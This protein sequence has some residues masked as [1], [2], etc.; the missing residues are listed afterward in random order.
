MINYEDYNLPCNLQQTDTTDA[1]LSFERVRFEYAPRQRKS[2]TGFSS[3][4]FSIKTRDLDSWFSFW[5]DLH[6]GVDSFNAIFFL[7]ANQNS[8]VL[9][10]TETYKLNNLGAGVF[11]INCA[12]EILH[13]YRPVFSD[14]AA[15]AFSDCAA[16][17]FDSCV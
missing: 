1:P 4:A 3:S 8:K 7:D 13:T 2:F 6:N 10:F 12:L 15:V 9:R 11:G 5:D 14:C 16:I 17:A